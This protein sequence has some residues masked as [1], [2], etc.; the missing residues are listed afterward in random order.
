MRNVYVDVGEARG[1]L[2]EIMTGLEAGQEVVTSGQLKLRNGAPVRVN[3]K[4]SVSASS[5]PQPDES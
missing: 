1:D 4:V 3:N 5:A 2:V